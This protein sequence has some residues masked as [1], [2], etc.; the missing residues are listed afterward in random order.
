MSCTPLFSPD[1]Q[2]SCILT[3]ISR[4]RE[5]VSIQTVKEGLWI[6]GCMMEKFVPSDAPTIQHT[7]T[8]LE[9]C[10]DTLEQLIATNIDDDVN[11]KTLGSVKDWTVLIPIFMELAKML[12]ERYLKKDV[13]QVLDPA[14]PAPPAPPTPPTPPTPQPPLFTPKS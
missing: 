5:G 3:F 7:F 8:D 10:L 4:V 6:S 9:S 11:S 12:L 13:E 14:P 1:M 2:L